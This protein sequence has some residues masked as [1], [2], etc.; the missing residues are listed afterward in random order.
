MDLFLENPEL[1]IGINVSFQ[2]CNKI[3]INTILCPVCLY[4]LIICT[5]LPV[6]KLWDKASLLNAMAQQVQI[7]VRTQVTIVVT[8]LGT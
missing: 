5:V 4:R 6:G 2:I 7:I 1:L 8:I 3:A